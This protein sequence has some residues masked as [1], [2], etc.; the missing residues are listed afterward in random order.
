METKLFIQ[1]YRVKTDLNRRKTT[2]EVCVV[3]WLM[4]PPAEN[5]MW[6]ICQIKVMPYFS[7]FQYYIHV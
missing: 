6:N 7:M 1:K 4:L 2:A 3:I 5:V